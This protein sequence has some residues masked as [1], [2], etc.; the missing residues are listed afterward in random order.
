MQAKKYGSVMFTDIK[1]SSDLWKKYP[2]EM[3]KALKEH[4]RVIS[5]SVDDHITFDSNESLKVLNFYDFINEQRVFESTKTGSKIIKNIG[6][7]LMIYFPE[8]GHE[9][10]LVHAIRCAYNIQQNFDENPIVVSGSDKIQIRI[11]ICY[12]EVNEI[13]TNVQGNDN[14][15]LFGATV[16]TASRM[17][18]VVSPV[19]GFA[20][21]YLSNNEL[22]ITEKNSIKEILGLVSDN[23]EVSVV[24][25][26]SDT[27]KHTGTDWLELVK[28]KIGDSTENSFEFTKHIGELT[29]DIESEEATNPSI[30]K[31]FSTTDLPEP[32]KLQSPKRSG[33]LI[34]TSD[35]EVTINSSDKLK[36]VGSLSAYKVEVGKGE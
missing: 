19:G 36:G 17:E 24:Y 13:T 25:F 34:D 22:D 29:G 16:N 23:V 27:E 35:S 28:D 20:F 2:E 3:D 21:S 7:A 5:E 32:I 4:F 10:P 26:V 12:G 6:D 30:I 15:D 31:K 33:R 18:S 8:G 9:H 14:T 11:G 1:G